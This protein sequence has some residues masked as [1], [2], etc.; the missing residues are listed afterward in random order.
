MR[1]QPVAQ[2][3]VP[4]VTSAQVVEMTGR[5][6]WGRAQINWHL[7]FLPGKLLKHTL[8]LRLISARITGGST[9]QV[10]EPGTKETL[11]SWT[12]RPSEM[13][14]KEQQTCFT[15]LKRGDIFFLLFSV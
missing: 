12:A 7:R 9:L 14:R 1:A 2:E 15:N 10:S 5:A 13:T 4:A 8:S 3:N 6:V 11:L